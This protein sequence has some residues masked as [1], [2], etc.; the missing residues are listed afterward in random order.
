MLLINR[1][2]VNLFERLKFF[3]RLIDFHIFTP[4]TNK[5]PGSLQFHLNDYLALLVTLLIRCVRHLHQILLICLCA[6][7][8]VIWWLLSKKCLC[9][10]STVFYWVFI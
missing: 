6:C 4:I 8:S 3:E 9:H 7:L 2:I 10:L 5:C 1:L